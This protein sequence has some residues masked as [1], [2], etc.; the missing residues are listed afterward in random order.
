MHEDCSH[1]Y[2]KCRYDRANNKS[3]K[4][5]HNSNQDRLLREESIKLSG[6]LYAVLNISSINVK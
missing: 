3:V 1:N 6:I 5:Q 4:S 2:H